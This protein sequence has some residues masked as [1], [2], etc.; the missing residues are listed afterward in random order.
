M[1]RLIIDLHFVFTNDLFN[2]QV[3][4]ELEPSLIESSLSM[5]TSRFVHLTALSGGH[6]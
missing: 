4:L 3:E 1:Y 2:N 6:I 5:F